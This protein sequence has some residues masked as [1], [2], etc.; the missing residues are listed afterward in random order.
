MAPL[1]PTCSRSPG[2]QQVS[3]GATQDGEL[4]PPGISSSQNLAQSIGCCL[5]SLWGNRG[6]EEALY[7][8]LWPSSWAQC[9]ALLQL[10][11]NHQATL[12]LS[13]LT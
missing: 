12:C 5:F 8:A 7:S 11:H 3:T 1:P 2:K 9:L 10:C 4:F 13:F 6:S